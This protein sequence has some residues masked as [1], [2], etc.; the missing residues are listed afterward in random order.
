MISTGRVAVVSSAI[1][2]NRAESSGT[3]TAP[4]RFEYNLIKLVNDWLNLGEFAWRRL[5]HLKQRLD[6]E[7]GAEVV[8]PALW[9]LEMA[10][11]LLVLERRRK[12]TPT[13]REEA[14][15]RLAALGIAT[16][17]EGSRLAFTKVSELAV[18]HGLSVYDAGYL[19]LSQRRRLRFVSRDRSLCAAAR[20]AGVS[21]L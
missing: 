14:L 19:E 2:P 21:S 10:N 13:E 8:V 16:D 1:L 12:I 20:R 4:L 11:A 18:E 9:F 6:L 5:A 3:E 7:S 17:E 15:S